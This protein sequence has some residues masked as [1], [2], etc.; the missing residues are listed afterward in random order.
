MRKWSSFFYEIARK[1]GK[2]ASFLMTSKRWRAEIR[3]GSSSAWQGKR[4]GKLTTRARRKSRIKS[5]DPYIE[6]YDLYEDG[7]KTPSL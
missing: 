2:T 1:A 3:S 6:L 5:N 7:R 4:F